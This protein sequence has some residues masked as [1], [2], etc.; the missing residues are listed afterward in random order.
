[1][2]GSR[3]N[4]RHLE[5]DGCNDNTDG[6]ATVL[7][8]LLKAGG[9][10][11]TINWRAKADALTLSFWNTA[12]AAIGIASTSSITAM[13]PADSSCTRRMELRYAERCG[14]GTAWAANFVKH[15]HCVRLLTVRPVPVDHAIG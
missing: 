2:R 13:A 3:L 4:R 14:N 7:S 15:Q 6:A 11:T 1:M 9:Y 12:N 10:L 5:T 8:G